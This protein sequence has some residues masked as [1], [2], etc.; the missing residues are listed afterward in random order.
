VSNLCKA[1]QLAWEYHSSQ[2]DKAGKPYMGHL[3]RVAARVAD[4]PEAMT[5]ALLHDLYEDVEEPPPLDCMFAWLGRK[6]LDTLETLTRRDGEAYEEFISRIAY[7]GNV[8]AIRVKIADLRDNLDPSRFLDAAVP[9]NVERRQ[10]YA[11]ALVK[12]EAMLPRY[13]GPSQH[14][15]CSGALPRGTAVPAHLQDDAWSGS[16]SVCGRKTWDREEAGT[17]CLMRQPGGMQCQGR[18][19]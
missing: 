12:L 17:V 9:G 19:H 1:I 13:E 7:S 4:D 11:Q 3:L 5:V 16:C 18:I 2:K 10:R 15:N 6:T 14:W 8:I